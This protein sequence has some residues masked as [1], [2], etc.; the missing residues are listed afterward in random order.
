MAVAVLLAITV[1][2]AVVCHY[3]AVRRGLKP[4]F[5]TVMGALFGPLA[6]PFVLFAG[7]RASTSVNSK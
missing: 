4:V 6:I 3:L 1:V 7:R 5:W 2:C